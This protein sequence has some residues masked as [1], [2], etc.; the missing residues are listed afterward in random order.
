VSW[1]EV[2]FKDDSGRVAQIGTDLTELELELKAVREERDRLLAYL[3]AIPG[4]AFMKDARRRLTYLSEGF[5]RNFGYPR[6]NA[7]GWR[8][9]SYL[10]GPIARK[11]REIESRLMKEGGSH[12]SVEGDEAV[13]NGCRWMI[14]RFVVGD[15]DDRFLGGLSLDITAV[16][17]VDDRFRASAEASVDAVGLLRAERDERGKVL[18]Y[19]WDYSNS[20]TRALFGSGATADGALFESCLPV[21]ERARIA[22]SL[23]RVMETGR[24]FSTCTS[25]GS[26]QIELKAARAGDLISLHMRDVT[27]ETKARE[28]E[29]RQIDDLREL[30]EK[31]ALTGLAN[32]A[33]FQEA[34]QSALSADGPLHV[35]LVIADVDRF[36]ELNDSLGHPAGD[37]ALKA[38]AD[39]LSGAVRGCDTVARIGGEEFAVIMPGAS[40][41]QAFAAAERLRTTIETLNFSERSLTAS[42]G[43]STFPIDAT[44]A[45]ELVATA[46]KALYRAKKAGRNRVVSA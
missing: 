46:D 4:I 14:H 37:R 26:A 1:L 10:P 6:S 39:A 17:G 15:G 34:L 42:F 7:I 29:R 33:R 43:A 5:D 21:D 8:D 35:S 38:V 19:R 22:A 13:E 32:R 41:E 44:G 40:R 24:E 16:R 27:Q 11:S 9:E 28:D 23:I 12:I 2:A 25:V 30:A 3:D 45:E 31:D 36:K 20:A 18:R